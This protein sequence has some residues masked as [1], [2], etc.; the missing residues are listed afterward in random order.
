MNL[1]FYP[2]SLQEWNQVI[3]DIANKLKSLLPDAKIDFTFFEYEET[4]LTLSLETFDKLCLSSEDLVFVPQDKLK[5]K[6]TF[7]SNYQTH[8]LIYCDLEFHEYENGIPKKV[9]IFFDIEE[10][11]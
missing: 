7:L 2:S 10:R 5:I 4:C 3:K 9:K 1:D 8:F 11:I 6:N